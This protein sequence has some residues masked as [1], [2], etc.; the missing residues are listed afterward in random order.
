[1][2]Y[3]FFANKKKIQERMDMKV[4]TTLLLYI[5]SHDKKVIIV[6]GRYDL[7][8][9]IRFIVI[10]C[11]TFQLTELVETVSKTPVGETQKYMCFEVRQAQAA[12]ERLHFCF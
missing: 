4:M 9:L 3:S 8:R 1:M 12:G 11:G 10:K 2:L 5:R 7:S 6:V